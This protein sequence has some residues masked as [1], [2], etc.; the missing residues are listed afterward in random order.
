[1]TRALA[2]QRAATDL[3]FGDIPPDR[4][5][6]GAFE[7]PNLDRPG[8][9]PHPALAARRIGRPGTQRRAAERNSA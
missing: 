3:R 6:L 1:M 5:R 7:H 2:P 9:Q 8:A 4:P